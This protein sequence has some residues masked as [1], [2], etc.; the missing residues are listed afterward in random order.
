LR[1]PAAIAFDLDGT[2]VDTV[3]ARIGAWLQALQEAGISV[4]HREVA[5][6][7]GS[8]GRYVARE[9]ARTVGQALE[10]RQA[11]IID[12]RQG[13][14][15]ELLN[16][17]P[18]PLPGSRE[19]LTTLDS[20]SIPWAIATSSRHEQVGA[21]V[22]ALRL[23]RPP[24][25]IDGHDVAQ[26]KP[27]PDLL[28]KACRVLDVEPKRCWYVGDSRWDMI[29][30]RA[31]GMVAVGVTAGSAVQAS[32]LTS[33]GAVRVCKTLRGLIQFIGRERSGIARVE[34]EP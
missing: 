18:K 6:L 14:I 8:D 33:A 1:P 13:E 10:D 30:A 22:Q 26:A 21:S 2:L 34:R 28:L 19:L 12:L 3:P 31:A 4:G 5:M 20:R 25:I 32:D 24:T 15:F 16:S 23:P 7:I 9:S 29:A 27:A 17:D 11:E